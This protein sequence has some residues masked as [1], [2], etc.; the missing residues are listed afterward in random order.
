MFCSTQFPNVSLHI[1]SD[2]VFYTVSICCA[3]HTFQ[4][5]PCTYFQ[6]VVFYT[7]SLCCALHTFQMFPC[8][9]FPDVV[10]YIFCSTQFPNVSLH[11]LS[12]CCVL[13]IF[14]M[15]C[16]THFPNVSLHILSRCCVL[17]SLYMLCSTH[18]P[19]SWCFLIFKSHYMKTLPSFIA[20]EI[21]RESKVKL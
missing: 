2:V 16:S 15:L 13:Y 10:F 20:G 9:Y 4:M 17:Y 19:N 5:F 8:T 12:C 14:Y 1:L 6:D 11:I 3:L 18:F 7:V 21:W